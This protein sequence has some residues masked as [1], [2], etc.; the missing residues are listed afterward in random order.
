MRPDDIEYERGDCLVLRCRRWFAD[1][2]FRGWLERRETAA[3]RGTPYH[4]EPSAETLPAG[5]ESTVPISLRLLLGQLPG[6]LVD[7][8]AITTAP[9]QSALSEFLRLPV[10]RRP[11]ALLKGELRLQLSR[12]PKPAPPGR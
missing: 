10:G 5:E 9:F 11:L 6:R 12:P 8:C 2:G 1:R 3:W 7:G 4:P